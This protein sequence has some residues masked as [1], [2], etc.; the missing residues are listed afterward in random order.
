M[1]FPSWLRPHRVLIAVVAVVT[2]VLACRD[3]TTSQE[4]STAGITDPR[5]TAAVDFNGTSL[6]RGNLGAFHVE[7]NAAHYNV[8]LNSHNNTDIA[9]SSIVVPPRGHSGWHYHPGP[10]LVVV[11]KGTITFYHGSDPT[12]SGMAH[13]AG[14]AFVEEG[15]DVGIA[16]NEGTGIMDTA[17]V[18]ATYFAPPGV[19]TRLDAPRPGNC[20]F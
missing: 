2:G 18:V 17:K 3:T 15:G 6:G 19:A 1:T 20:S 13:P 4:R 12:C 8:E 5:F 7:S 16:R 11:T 9:V 14:T 10:V